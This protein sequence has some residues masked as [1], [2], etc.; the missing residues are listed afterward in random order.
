MVVAIEPPVRD[1]YITLDGMR[2]HY[3][4]WGDRAAPVLVLLHAYT[5]HARS[6]DTFAAGMVD[7]FRVLALDQRGHGESEWASDYHELRLVSDLAAFVDALE[8]ETF[9]LVGFSIGGY[10]ACAYALLYP[11]RVQRLVL[12]ECFVEDPSEV[13]ASTEGTEHIRAL[14]SLPAEFSGAAETVSAQ[15][16][17]AYRPLAPFAE[18]DELRRWMLGGLKPGQD[19]RWTLRYDRVLR[20]PGPPGRLNA[21]ADVFRARLA[22]VTTPTLLVVGADSFHAESAE[23]DAVLNPGKRLAKIPQAGHWVPLDNPAGFVKAVRGFLLG[24]PD[25]D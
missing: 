1:E 19:D 10:A 16:A 13:H 17:A 4:D 15:A 14:R 11:R 8:L 6:W 18:E 5:S 23:R 3:R 20:A 21:I 25:P 9:S 7:R 24:D 12:A 2:F 22:S